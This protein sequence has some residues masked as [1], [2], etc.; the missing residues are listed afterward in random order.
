MKLKF[1]LENTT[2]EFDATEMRVSDTPAISALSQAQSLKRIADMLE[3]FSR[4]PALMK[5]ARDL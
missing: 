2:L 3:L 5:L 1:Q 4:H